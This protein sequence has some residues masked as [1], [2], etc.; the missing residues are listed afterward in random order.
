VSTSEHSCA[1]GW[2]RHTSTGSSTATSSRGTFVIT[3]EGHLKILDVG[4]AKTIAQPQFPVVEALT[5]SETQDVA[6]IYRLSPNT[7]LPSS[8]SS[9]AGA[10]SPDG[11]ENRH[12]LPD[13]NLPFPSLSKSYPLPKDWQRTTPTPRLRPA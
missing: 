13:K 4:L 2:Q 5:L 6:C 8:T 10:R 9:S 12:A 7:P 11:A 1:T 3:P